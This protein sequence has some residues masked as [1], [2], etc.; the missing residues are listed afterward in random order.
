MMKNIG[1][2]VFDQYGIQHVVP[3]CP[4]SYEDWTLGEST[5]REHERFVES[6][7]EALCGVVYQTKLRGQ[8]THQVRHMRPLALAWLT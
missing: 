5:S 7:E 6:L 3:G 4:R 8:N 1:V 2:P